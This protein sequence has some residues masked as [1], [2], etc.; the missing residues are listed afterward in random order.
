MGKALYRKYRPRSLSEVVGQPH[1]TNALEKSLKSG[2]ISHAYLFIGPRGTGK[3]SVARILA[4][5][6]NGFKYELEDEYLD[7]LEIDAASNTGVDNVRSLR[8]NAQLTPTQG[9]YKVY[10]IDE[11][12]MLSKS[13]FNALLKTLEEPPA[14]VIFVMATTDAHKVPIT[15]TSRS[16][17]Y[18]F[19]LASTD[20]IA[21]HLTH[22]TKSEKIKIDSDAI[23]LIAKRSG[24]SFR[25][26][27]SLLDQISTSTAGCITCAL[28]NDAFGLPSDEL[29]VTLLNSYS[30]GDLTRAR[31]TLQDLLEQGIKPE[32]I[33]EDLI[34]SI[35]TDLKPTFLPLLNQLLD[36]PSSSRPE[37]KLLLTL[38]G[39]PASVADFS[40]HGL[41]AG[42]SL[43]AATTSSLPLSSQKAEAPQSLATEAVNKESTNKLQEDREPTSFKEAVEEGR[44]APLLPAEREGRSPVKT[45]ASPEV[46]SEKDVG[47]RS[48]WT[49]LLD[50]IH[51]DNPAFHSLL[52]HAT[53]QYDQNTLNIY[54]KNKMVRNKIDQKLKYLASFLPEDT[55]IQLNDQA[56]TPADPLINDLS[57][58]FGNVEE[59]E[60]EHDG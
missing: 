11:V 10:I 9:K 52:T 17:T 54:I 37:V 44:A 55:N 31:S 5:E 4:H 53:G 50:I 43:R 14:H 2:K 24:G 40:E 29:I 15:I 22:I 25:D 34:A 1:I 56:T 36:I 26:A 48:S 45:G 42:P 19:K 21:D 47:S 49:E 51:N 16:Q 59:V 12:H 38:L 13:A 20:T 27:I 3:T 58:I 60:L 28:L 23:N 18:T 30:S 39:A 33:A 8:E 7:I 57:S 41:G 6:I 32:I 35:I 46:S